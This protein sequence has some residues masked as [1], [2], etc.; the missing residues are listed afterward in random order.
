MFVIRSLYN[1][2][3]LTS[4]CT[5]TQFKLQRFFMSFLVTADTNGIS[6]NTSNKTTTVIESK[7]QDK[8]LHACMHA[9]ACAYKKLSALVI[10]LSLLLCTRTQFMAQKSAP[11][12]GHSHFVKVKQSRNTPIEAQEGRGCIAPTHSRPR[13]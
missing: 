6:A 7:L 1:C 3:R 12:L 11:K 2:P 8:K 13:H 5:S 10:R 4:I 9:R